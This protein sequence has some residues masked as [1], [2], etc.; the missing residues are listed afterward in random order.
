M[1]AVS[2]VSGE[3]LGATVVATDQALSGRTGHVNP[4]VAGQR[5]HRRA[6]VVSGANRSVRSTGGLRRI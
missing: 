2:S 1:V 4:H 5:D 3:R 6:G